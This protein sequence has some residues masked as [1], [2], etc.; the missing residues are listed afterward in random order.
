M[1]DTRMGDHMAAATEHTPFQTKTALRAILDAHGLSPRKRYGQHFLIDRN[2][3]GKLLTSAELGPTD[4]VLEIGAGTGSLTAL[5]AAHAGRVVAVEIDEELANLAEVQLAGLDNVEL[6]R[7]DALARKSALAPALETAVLSAQKTGG[8][9]LKLVANLPYDIATPLV[10]ELLVGS[11]PFERFCFTVQAE[12][13]DRFLA[14]SGEKAYGTV[15]ILADI[16][17]ERGR[18]CRVP[19]QAFWPVPKVASAMICLR[20]RAKPDVPLAARRE[21]AEFVKFFFGHRRKTMAR[22]ARSRPDAER[23]LSAMAAE[24][25]A[26]ESRPES[27]TPTQW[28]RLFATTR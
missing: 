20:S 25:I 18:V 15:S 11:V 16:F 27:L 21:F 9:T 3:M 4:C 28:A 10:A 26:P 7:C 5:L 13:A 2:L 17:T 24:D 14:R 12:V 1:G 6:L 22:T 8:G 23:L 19:P